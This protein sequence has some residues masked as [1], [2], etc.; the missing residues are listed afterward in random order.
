[1]SVNPGQIEPVVSRSVIKR[2]S[3][4]CPEF[5]MLHDALTR[6]KSAYDEAQRCPEMVLSSGKTDK[7]AKLMEEVEDARE[8]LFRFC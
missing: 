8:A 5:K 1:M 6:Y 3:C 2:L 4:Q 7:A